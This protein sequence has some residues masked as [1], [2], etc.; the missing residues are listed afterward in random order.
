MDHAASPAATNE[1]SKKVS[2]HE[3]AAM[4]GFPVELI[5]QELFMGQQNQDGVSLEELRA[6]MLNFIDATL[7]D[8]DK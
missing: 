5:Q 3:L 2:L 6:A 4:T 8:D 7:I 1:A